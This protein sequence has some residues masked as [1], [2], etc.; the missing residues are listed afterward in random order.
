MQVIKS[1]NATM[2]A[3]LAV[4]FTAAFFLSTFILDGKF[5][6]IFQAISIF[7]S[8]SILFYVNVKNTEIL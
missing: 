5:E 2:I 7:L 8:L 1:P 3:I 4:L 6:L